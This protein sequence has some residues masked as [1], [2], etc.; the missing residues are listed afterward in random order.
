MTNNES[1]SDVVQNIA[2]GC[3]AGKRVLVTGSGVGIGRGIAEAFARGGAAV[4]LHYFR[5][6]TG[7]EETLINIRKAGGRAALFRADFA[8]VASVRELAR[9]AVEFLGGID[10]LVNNAGITLNLPIEQITEKQFDLLYAVNTRAPYFLCQQLIP[11]LKKSGGVIIN[12]SSIHAYEGYIEHSVY[13]GTRGAIVA[14]TRQ[15]AIELAPCG[16]RVVGIA[17][18]SVL[19]ENKHGMID[20]KALG[21]SIPAGFA[22]KPADIGA[23]AVFL[24]SPGARYIV[25]QTLVVDG[26]TTSWMPFG[27]QFK[28][29]M[30]IQFGQGY[31]PG[32]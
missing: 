21:A 20:E 2:D 12:I 25:G 3:M 17:P 18:G 4:A 13:A 1:L 26:G 5:S 9:Q 27:E 32:V 24:A 16:I 28:Q 31:V 19:T 22:G 8:D 7:A 30:N 23:V 6:G 29:P 11:E 15:L 10:V 14:F